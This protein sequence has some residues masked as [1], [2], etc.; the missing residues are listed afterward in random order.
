MVST[1][2]GM[3]QMDRR[4]LI[5]DLAGNAH[6]WVLA[7]DKINDPDKLAEC[8]GL[9]SSDETA[10]CK[11]FRFD[12]DRRLYL[13]SH[14]MLRRVLSAYT[15]VDP[16]AWAFSNQAMGRPEIASPDPGLPLRFNLT[17]TRGL[18]ACVVT[19]SVDCGVDAEAL[20][21]RRHAMDVAAR[22]FA[23]EEIQVLRGL[24]GQAF[25]EQFYACWTLREAYCKARG[26]GLASSGKH[27]RFER[28]RHGAWQLCSSDAAI[29]DEH[30]QLAVE[31]VLDNHRV[32][33]AVNAAVGIRLLQFHC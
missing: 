3:Q 6:V 26:S 30:W 17:H 2:T 14:A 21:V 20:T 29:S 9:L 4:A 7:T 8:A 11:R 24:Q 1:V 10:R 25:L 5:T 32:A 13:L 31:H 16:A 12:A 15:D 27:F 19:Q 33:V 23:D 22:M 28:D 18:A